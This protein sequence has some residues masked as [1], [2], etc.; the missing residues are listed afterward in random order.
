MGY[1]Q[2]LCAC[3]CIWFMWLWMRLFIMCVNSSELTWV[4]PLKLP[5]LSNYFTF[6]L[7][8]LF[9]RNSGKSQKENK[10]IFSYDIL[11]TY[12][13]LSSRMKWSFPL[14]L[15]VLFFYQVAISYCHVPLL[16]EESRG[17]KKESNVICKAQLESIHWVCLVSPSQCLPLFYCKFKFW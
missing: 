5:L 1:T 8:T 10:I 3:V 2:I 16:K 9:W 13:L 17:Y 6:C 11:L 14:F 15:F 12:W 7:Q 4:R